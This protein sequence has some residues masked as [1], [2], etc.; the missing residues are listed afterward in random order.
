MDDLYDGVNLYFSKNGILKHNIIKDKIP[1][2]ITNN[3]IINLEYDNIEP[4]Y[5]LIFTYKIIDS[6]YYESQINKIIKINNKYAPSNLTSIDFIGD[7]DIIKD[8]LTGI[9]IWEYLPPI[10]SIDGVEIFITDTGTV[11]GDTDI[12]IAKIT[13]NAITSYT[14]KKLDIKL[15][16]NNINLNNNNIK[17]ILRTYN[18]YNT[19]SITSSIII[20]DL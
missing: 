6:L 9:L 11:F 8:E 1:K 4:L 19:S 2:S 7:L 5:I 16:K 3:N 18:R 13:S 17:F 10:E 14:F 20:T 12:S 15:V